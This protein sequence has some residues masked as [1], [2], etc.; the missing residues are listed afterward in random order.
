MR[1]QR[2]INTVILRYA[3]AQGVLVPEIEG[4]LTH[5]ELVQSL[6]ADEPRLIL[7]ELAF[8]SPEGTRRHAQL[9]ILWVPPDPAN[10]KRLIRT[11]SQPCGSSSPMST[12][13]SPPGERISSRTEGSLPWPAENLGSLPYGSG[14][15]APTTGP[16]RGRGRRWS[17][18]RRGRVRCA[19]RW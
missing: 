15:R 6:P 3:G 19:R 2:E 9:L 13:T 10:R 12:S 17:C 4:N 1:E 14:G 7:H 11:D 18:R 16:T 5:D 8:A